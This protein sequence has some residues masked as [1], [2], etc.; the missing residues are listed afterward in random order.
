MNI[1]QS[2]LSDEGN[3]CFSSNRG[4]SES[5]RASADF[6]GKEHRSWAI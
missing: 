6:P 3:D 4:V 5:F 1:E 2:F